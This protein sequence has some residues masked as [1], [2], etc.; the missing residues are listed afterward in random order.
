MAVSLIVGV[1]FAQSVDKKELI[2]NPPYVAPIPEKAAWTL[3]VRQKEEVG[4]N[5]ENATEVSQ[6]PEIL[7]VRVTKIDSRQ[8]KII[9][10]KDGREEEL[11]FIDQFM[12]DQS[13]DNQK[14]YVTNMDIIAEPDHLYRDSGFYG[15]GWLEEQY[16]VG[17]KEMEGKE[18]FYFERP[19]PIVESIKQR[20]WI[21]M[22]SKL[23]V[24]AEGMNGLVIYEFRSRSSGDVRLPTEF[25]EAWE[26]H[27]KRKRAMEILSKRLP[28]ANNS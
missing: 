3:V 12:I 1:S 19:H 20:A 15:V 6:R 22:K 17:T 25:L 23:P 13:P 4:T 16:F 11:F 27:Q 18:C 21:D 28:A 24:A 5:G 2:P 26:Q 14:V 7:S 10:W 9:R 8:R